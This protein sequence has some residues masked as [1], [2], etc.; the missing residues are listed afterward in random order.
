MKCDSIL[1]SCSLLSWLAILGIASCISA[2][3]AQPAATAESLGQALTF[4]ASFD[5][6]PDADFG[7]GDRRVFMAPS[8]KPPRIGTPG[9]PT[10]NVVSIA[11]GE[12]RVGD[13]LR[14]HRKASEIVFYQAANN[15]AYSTSNWSGTVSFW[16]RLDPENDLEPGYCD[17]IQ[18]T[19]RE[20][21]DAALWVDFSKDE[22]PRHFRLG[23]FA[24][25]RV[26]DPTL[27][28]L[29]KTPESERPMVTV[30]KPPFS[31]QHW[32]HVVFTFTNF[33]TGRKDG[34]ATL[35]LEGKSQGTVSVR[36][37][38]F[39][40]EPAKT[41]T[42]I[43]LNYTGLF[44]ELALFSRALTGSEV[45]TLYKSPELVRPSRR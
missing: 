40:W 32:T 41:V 19:P 11:K 18:I 38:T 24:D 36:E 28:D 42:M 43:G 4:Y 5:N 30:T 34:V 13:A 45:E 12:G 21:N 10:N 22:R 14:F 23:V 3:A 26:W 16:L 39:T 27:R 9:L 35:Y 6:G 33:N 8:M 31:R 7:R 29:D 17:P 25:R 37:Q 15:V 2:H 44:D 1:S 20:W